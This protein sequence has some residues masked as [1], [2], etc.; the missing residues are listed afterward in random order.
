MKRD[1]NEIQN[2]YNNN[3]TWRDIIKN[4]KISNETLMKAIKNNLLKTRT[5]SDANTISNIKKTRILSDETKQKISK[6]RIKYLKEHPD[7]VPYLLNHSSKGESFPEK[8]FE[9]ILSKTELKYKR[10][11]QISIYQLDFAFINKKINLEIDGEQHYTDLKII[12]SN[13]NRNLF[14][15]NNGWKTIRI[16]W[17]DYQKLNREQKEKKISKLINIIENKIEDFTPFLNGKIDG[18]FY[19]GCGNTKSKRSKT[20]IKCRISK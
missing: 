7:Q 4:F 11:Y 18:K 5:K 10:Y 19:C 3:H 9:S 15:E 12:E 14:L 17:S 8:Y 6:S 2:Y 1:W 20:C 16:R 13:K